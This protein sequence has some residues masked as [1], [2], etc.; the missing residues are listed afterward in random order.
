MSQTNNFHIFHNKKLLFNLCAMD[1]SY[2][3]QKCLEPNR[4][5]QGIYVTRLPTQTY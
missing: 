4:S 3:M 1:R 5:R 2:G